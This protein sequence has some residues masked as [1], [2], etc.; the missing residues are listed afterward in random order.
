MEDRFNE[1]VNRLQAALGDKLVSVV[2]YGSAVAVLGN[3]K[4]SDYRTLIVSHALSADQLNKARPAVQWWTAEGFPLPVFFTRQE[5]IDS[6]D[7]FPVEFR[8]MKRAY[9]VLYGEDLLAPREAAK[10]NLRWQV[11][12][13]LRGK[14][15]RL[16]SLYLP[17]GGSSERLTRLM[18]D[19]VVSFVRYL[20][21]LLEILDETPPLGRLATVALVG[22]RLE[23]DVTPLER[24]LRLRDEPVR[25]LE[26]EAQDLF[27]S[28]VDCLHKI[29]AA[30]DKL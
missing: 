21:P 16:R 20:R 23:L 8:Q 17:E 18:T 22:E 5:F 6:L 24:L 30:V 12:Y 28:Y 7:V 11:E 13:E 14:L 10:D 3:P 25:L 2:V 1:L 19:S 4:K 27:A 15:L 9:R 26:A 29:I